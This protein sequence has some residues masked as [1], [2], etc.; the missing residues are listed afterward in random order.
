MRATVTR[1]FLLPTALLIAGCPKDEPDESLSLGE[2]SEALEE[3]SLS[4]Q[5]M[6]AVSGTVEISTNFTIGQAAEKAADE[7]RS[8]VQSQLPCAEI[9]LS[10]ATLT[11]EYGAKSGSCSYHGQT[12]SGKHSVTVARNEEGHVQV[13]HV[14]KD[15]SNSRVSVSGTAQVVWSLADKTRHVEHTLTWTRLSDRR[16]GTGTGSR[17]QKA[18]AGGIAE[19]IQVDGVRTWTGPAGEWDKTI[20]GVQMRWIDPVPQSGTVTLVTPK[21]KTLTMQFTRVD[22]DTIKVTVSNGAKSFDI[23]V[24]KL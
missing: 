9:S 16:T 24:N 8:F 3:S 10:K 15:L 22:D 1:L 18:L 5:A 19:G 11:I 23:N 6:N 21:D 2:A 13:D 12:Y 20:N 17:T 7:L 14:W 4:D